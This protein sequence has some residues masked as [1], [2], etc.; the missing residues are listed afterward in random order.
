MKAG[1]EA[2]VCALVERVFREFVAPDYGPEGIEVFFTFANPEAMA[3]RAGPEQV[4]VV[5]E[6]GS[7][8]VGMIEMRGHDHIAMLFVSRHRQGIAKELLRLAVQEC[9][10]RRPEVR[11]ITVNSSP[12]AEPIYRRMGFVATGP[13]QEKKG[14]LFV[15]MFRSL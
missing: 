14:I 11:Q 2:Q 15:P 13:V 6:Q 8:M 5:A 4:I 9:R 3:Q 1:E 12:F 7:E 10:R